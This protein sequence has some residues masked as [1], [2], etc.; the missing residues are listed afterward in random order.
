MGV[1]GRPG[2]WAAASFIVQLA[3]TGGVSVVLVACVLLGALWHREGSP[4]PFTY[5]LSTGAKG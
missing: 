3:L 4:N 5:L 2:W 1:P